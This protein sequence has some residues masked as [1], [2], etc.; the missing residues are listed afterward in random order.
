MEK[1]GVF[2]I[3]FVFKFLK[4]VNLLKFNLENMFLFLKDVKELGLLD[5]DINW[6]MSGLRWM[7]KFGNGEIFDF[8]KDDFKGRILCVRG[9]DM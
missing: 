2:M 3:F 8:L 5:M 4:N 6:F 7:F 1:L 9:R